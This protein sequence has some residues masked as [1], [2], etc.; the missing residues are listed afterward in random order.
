MSWSS[1]ARRDDLP[2]E[3]ERIRAKVKARARGRCEATH[4]APGC[5]RIGTDA[6]HIGDRNDHS[7]ANL[8]WLSRPCHDVK[9]RA[10]LGLAVP[11]R[12]P[13][14]PHPGAMGGTLPPPRRRA[15]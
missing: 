2:P 11:V 15:P 4:H 1:S 9:T 6:D 12:R 8:Q 5:R 3:W 7:L 14:E 13:A 10:D